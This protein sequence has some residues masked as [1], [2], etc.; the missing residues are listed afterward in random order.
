MA[1]LYDGNG[2][3]IE[4][5]GGT[6]SAFGVTD[7]AAFTDSSGDS[8]RQAVLTYNGTKLYPVN[9]SEQ[10]LDS[11]KDYGG[12]VMLAF[13]DSYTVGIGDKWDN[14]AS[15][16]NLVCDIQGLVG[17]AYHGT[18]SSAPTPYWLR[19]NTIINDYIAGK[20]IGGTTYTASDVK[21]IT[22][23]GGANDGWSK[24]AIGDSIYTTDKNTLYGACH[25]V[26]GKLLQ[27]FPNA[28]IVCILQ[29]IQWTD[30]SSNTGL[31]DD[32]DA[33]TY[34]FET[35]QDAKNLNG[36]GYANFTS[37]IN[38]YAIR[39]VAEMYGLTICD[40]ALKW[41]KRIG[42]VDS[43]AYWVTD[44]HMTG[45]GY[46]AILAQLEKTVNSLPFSRNK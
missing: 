32:E 18:E 14:F 3:V 26:F 30:S 41:Y 7:Y 10:Q 17:S 1:K 4:I 5:S 33:Q 8:A 24:A 6:S 27:T 46:A 44:G 38:Q 13:G 19:L 22:V 21:L 11:A 43:S 23:M 37:T 25:Y 2:N 16:H 31:T 20:T 9:Y 29:P 28:D 42:S 35:V 34:G 39:Q 15:K 36:F 40:C 45:T 12:G